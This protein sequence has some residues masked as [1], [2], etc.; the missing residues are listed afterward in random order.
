MLLVKPVYGTQGEWCGYDSCV[1]D[2]CGEDN[3]IIRQCGKRGPAEP[4]LP[5]D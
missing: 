5:T 4:G 2:S 3:C 1:I